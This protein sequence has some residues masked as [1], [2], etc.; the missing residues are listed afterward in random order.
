MGGDGWRCES[1]H[2]D[3]SKDLTGLEQR[4]HF[5]CLYETVAN[6]VVGVNAAKFHGVRGS[7]IPLDDCTFM[8]P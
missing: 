2:S 3:H 5:A 8:F 1:D 4:I 7:L 6:F